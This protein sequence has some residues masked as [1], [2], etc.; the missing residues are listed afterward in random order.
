V[1]LV[2]EKSL[3][4]LIRKHVQRDWLVLYEG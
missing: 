3:H 1:D 2:I 4:P